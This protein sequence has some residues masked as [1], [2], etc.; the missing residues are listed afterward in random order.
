MTKEMFTE[1]LDLARNEQKRQYIRIDMKDDSWYVEFND[2]RDYISH[3][4][5]WKNFLEIEMLRM[6]EITDRVFVSYEEIKKV[7]VSLD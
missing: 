6:S 4:V 5:P 3:F 1:I 7:S 2:N